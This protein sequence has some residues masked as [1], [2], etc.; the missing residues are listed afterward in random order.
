MGERVV[1][2]ARDEQLKRLSRAFP[3]GKLV[4]FGLEAEARELSLLRS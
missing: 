1:A 2:M 4:L 3:A